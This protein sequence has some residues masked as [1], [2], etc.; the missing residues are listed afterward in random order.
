MSFMGSYE[1]C[2]GFATEFIQ[3]LEFRI[4]LRPHHVFPHYYAAEFARTNVFRIRGQ[5]RSK[6]GSRW[7]LGSLGWCEKHSMTTP[8]WAP[9][10]LSQIDLFDRKNVIERAPFL[11]LLELARPEVTTR[12]TTRQW[13]RARTAWFRWSTVTS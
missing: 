8:A 7:G 10:K 5:F 6:A 9:W 1:R 3:T 12:S 2:R 4:R 11:V 13:S